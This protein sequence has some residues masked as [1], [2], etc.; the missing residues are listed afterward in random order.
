MSG[1]GL[2]WRHRRIGSRYLLLGGLHDADEGPAPLVTT[3][4]QVYIRLRRSAYPKEL[5]DEWRER[6]RAYVGQ[7]LE[8]FCYVKHEDN[9]DA[10]RLALELAEGLT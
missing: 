5:L 9:P 1:R 3:A 8:V 6:I 4:G 10:P 7:G 2:A